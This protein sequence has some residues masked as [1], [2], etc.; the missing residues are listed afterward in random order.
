[1]K[2]ISVIVTYADRFNLLKQVLDSCLISDVS[3]IIIVDNNSDKNSREKLHLF[4]H[5]NCVFNSW[6]SILFSKALSQLCGTRSSIQLPSFSPV[7]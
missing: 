2:V 4:S 3:K 5:A 6:F 7:S 1:M